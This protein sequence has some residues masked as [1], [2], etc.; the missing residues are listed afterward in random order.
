MGNKKP[1]PGQLFDPIENDV[2]VRI[3]SWYAK[4]LLAIP[5]RSSLE[6]N[7]HKRLLVCEL[8]QDITDIIEYFQSVSTDEL[9]RKF[10]HANKLAYEIFNKHAYLPGI[11]FTDFQELSQGEALTQ[12]L[13]TLPEVI[14]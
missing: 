7:R 11:S 14:P 5:R 1:G 9:M 13:D 2:L 12:M 10:D 4:T 8:M 6:N 3:N